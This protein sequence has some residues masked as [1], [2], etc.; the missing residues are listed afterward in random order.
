MNEDYFRDM[1]AYARAAVHD[2]FDFHLPKG[3]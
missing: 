3:A 1:K 2:M